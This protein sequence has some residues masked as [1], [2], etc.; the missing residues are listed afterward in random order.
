MDVLGLIKKELPKFF[1]EM[2]VPFLGKDAPQSVMSP[3]D[4]RQTE[5]QTLET[6]LSLGVAAV[7]VGKAAAGVAKLAGA[8]PKTASIA[9]AAAT[10]DPTAVITNPILALA[11]QSNDAEASIVD[12]SRVVA[13]TDLMKALR[14]LAK[15]ADPRK[16]FEQYNVYKGPVD[17]F[18][19]SYISDANA[20][21]KLENFYNNDPASGYHS[22]SYTTPVNLEDILDHPELFKAV[23]ELRDVKVISG[24]SPRSGSFDEKTRSIVMPPIFKDSSVGNESEA[25]SVLLHEVNHAIQT[26]FGL[27]KGGSPSMFTPIPSD[28]LKNMIKSGAKLKDEKSA[29]LKRLKEAGKPTKD[30]EEFIK[31]LDS[32]LEQ[33]DNMNNEA[34]GKYLGLGGEAES[35]ATQAMFKNET[36]NRYFQG[37]MERYGEWRT[38]TRYNTSTYPLDYYDVDPTKVTPSPLD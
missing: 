13:R 21:F 29:E 28:I 34:F 6:L 23:P 7:P 3:P 33:L 10:G 22:L 38:P 25:M 36:F 9:T 27:T 11:A 20:K 18:P 1:T 37:P 31:Q 15:G 19:R 24:T 8:Y 14:E 30:T 32:N 2:G 4:P 17:E 12:A 26:E 5:K 35:R 16:V